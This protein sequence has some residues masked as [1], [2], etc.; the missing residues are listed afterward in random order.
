MEEEV[1]IFIEIALVCFELQ[2]IIAI[3]GDHC[4]CN[5]ALTAHGID[6]D[7]AA[8]YVQDAQQ[9]RNGGDFIGFGIHFALTQQQMVG[10]GP[11]ADQMNGA[12]AKSLVMR[13]A[14]RLVIKRN[15]LPTTLSLT[16]AIQ[17]AKL[18]SNCSRVQHHKDSPEGVM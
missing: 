1:N 7:N 13:A 14:Q 5:G 12:S 10:A 6:G 9:L 16:A 3:L 11:G 4:L 15:H 17:L 2:Q 8:A 18:R